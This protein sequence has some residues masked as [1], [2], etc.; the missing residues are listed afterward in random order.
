MKFC[1]SIESSDYCSRY[2]RTVKARAKKARAK[3]A[4]VKPNMDFRNPTAVS[5]TEKGIEITCRD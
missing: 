5:F 4:Q 3:K 1:E 2:G